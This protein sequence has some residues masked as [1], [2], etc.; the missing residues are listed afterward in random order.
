MKKI[1]LLL[2]FPFIAFSQQSKYPQD[3]FRN[4]LNIP[5]LLAGNFGECR[6]NH[7]H[8]GIDI[9]TLGKE[10]LPV[11]AAADGYIS[12]IKMD[13]GG[14]GHALYI[15]HPNGFTTL[16]AHLNDFMPS[17]QKYTKKMQYEKESWS[18]DLSLLPDQ[19]PVKK[20]QQIAW[21][22]NTGGSAGPHLHFEIRDTKTEHPLNPMLFGFPIVDTRSPVPTQLSFYDMNQSI[23]NQNAQ[24]TSLKKQG[25]VYTTVKDTVEV[26]TDRL[27][28]GIN[29]N[30]FMNGS[31]NTL[32][33]YTA[34]WYM[35][36]VLQG[37][38][39]LD[40]I[41]YDVTRYLHA[42]VDY[43][44]RKQK[45]AWFQ[46]LFQ[47]PGN[48]LSH[49]YPSL[50][51]Q[52]G[53][54]VLNDNAAHRVRVELKDAAGNQ[55]NISFFVK[56]GATT[57]GAECTNRFEVNSPNNFEHPN[58]RFALGDKALYQDV[59]FEFS[60]KSDEKNFSDRY[61]V[62]YSYV[63]V[64]TYFDLQIKPNKP[65]P[66]NLRDKMVMMYSDGKSEDGRAAIFENGWYK[67]SVRNFG[68]YWLT[69]DTTAPVITSLQV[70][71]ANLATAKQL[72]FRVKEN[73]TSVKNFR[74]TLNGKWICFEPRGDIFFYNFDEH[75]PKGKH[76]L[77][78]TVSDEN[79]NSKTLVFNF[80]R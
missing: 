71:N 5:I 41:G 64:H 51:M 76:K 33:F 13:K 70:Q 10:N 23:Y 66:F 19:F 15:T 56:T 24:F 12:R 62:H 4:P 69:T 73:I 61:Q 65:V 16:Y 26:N 74:A 80:T 22:G 45:S 75:C 28:I 1:I 39:L 2:L 9:K 54:L 53:N 67:S 27:G 18:V 78:I 30:D 34:S 29:V 46:L 77:T 7:F 21:S 60:S 11:F 38:I 59:C 63:P 36:N 14:F 50:N 42:Y 43:K 57:R 31:A 79:N 48:F 32:N 58:I 72:R 35:D 37:S 17:V 40:D 49:I 6:P 55:T 68:N 3:Y 25:N 8:S 44:T 20:G 52:K 47:L